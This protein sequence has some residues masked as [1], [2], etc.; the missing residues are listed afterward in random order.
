MIY[1][2]IIVGIDRSE[3]SKA[4]LVEAARLAKSSGGQLS[5]VRGEYSDTE[6]FSTTAGSAEKKVE[7]GKELCEEIRSTFTA[8]CN[9][10]MNCVVREGEP[11]EVIVEVADELKADLIAMG[12]HGRKGLKR[13]I[14]G[15]VTWGVI[16]DAKCDILVVRKR[17]KPGCEAY[18][19]ILLPYDG[20]DLSKK[21]LERAIEFKKESPEIVVTLL[22]VIPRYEEMIGFI[23][24]E[25]IQDRLYEE[26]RKIV[27]TGLEIAK[28]SDV[29]IS[30][31]MEEGHPTDKIIDIAAGLGTDLVVMGSH[32]WRGFSKAM[33]G[34]TAERVITHSEVPVLI[35]R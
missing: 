17:N 35:A 23:R 27:L 2:N 19:N 24:T 13:M 15:S 3:F 11:H 28:K 5:L 16:Q 7:K 10:E 14:M 8:E 25:A 9:V 22:Y 4:A 20:S 26:A 32:G 33:L 12:T 34:S 18:G 29:S 30:T 31:I 6:E 21:A 1:K